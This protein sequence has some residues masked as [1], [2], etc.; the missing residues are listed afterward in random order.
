MLSKLL[1]GVIVVFSI[2]LHEI[3]HGYV[4]LLCGDQTAKQQKRLTLNPVKHIDLVGT[5]IMPIVM[6]LTL[7]IAVG[8]AKPV[9]VNPYNFKK[10][11]LGIFL[12]ALAGPFTNIFIAFICGL[13]LKLFSQSQLL[14]YV[15][16]WAGII[17]LLL[18]SFNL[19]PIPPLDGSKI[20]LSLV[21]RDV[22]KHIY[23][24]EPYGFII[25]IALFYMGI[26]WKILLPI[27]S[28]LAWMIGLRGIV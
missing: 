28:V 19:I 27:V 3:A 8:S 9:P 21:P 12:V 6:I 22:A 25:I 16:S 2:I 26:L 7:G 5:I 1:V 15:F 14:A 18:A 10:A 20:L 11:R 24:I 17:N 23:K 13:G 4:A